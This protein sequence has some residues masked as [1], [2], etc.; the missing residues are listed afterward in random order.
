[1]VSTKL[2]QHYDSDWLNTSSISSLLRQLNSTYW[3]RSL[4]NPFK[5]QPWE[6]TTQ[7]IAAGESCTIPTPNLKHVSACHAL[8]PYD[9]SGKWHGLDDEAFNFQLTQVLAW[10]N[11]EFF[12]HRLTNPCMRCSC[13]LAML[14]QDQLYDRVLYE[15]V[16]LSQNRRPV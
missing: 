6:P 13:K 16:V 4:Q 9:K 12:P 10:S 11:S 2:S 15:L 3:K 1:M 7:S 5:F 8:R 14:L